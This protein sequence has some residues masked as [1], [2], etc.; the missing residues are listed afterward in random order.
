VSEADLQLAARC[1]AGE[2]QA[3][4]EFVRSYRGFMIDFARR[5]VG[6]TDAD[7]LADSVLADLWER[8][9]LARFEGRSSLRTWL[10]AVVAHAA[11]NHR[12]RR[13]APAAPPHAAAVDASR[14]PLEDAERRRHLRVAL[15]EA[16]GGLAA[17]D[18]VLLL[19]HY[20]QGLTLDEAG[21]VLDASKST[22]SRRLTRTR[23]HLRRETAR[24]AAARFGVDVG[25]LW[26]DGGMDDADFDL[27]A[28]CAPLR[29]A[30]SGDVSKS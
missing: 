10:G 13:P 21:A 17:E 18:R 23:E 8:R 22:L 7:E 14:D 2:E 30:A 16:F 12:R 27:R 1:T 26:R 15:I 29:D 11:L 19:M 25:R 24:I 3:W 28:V 6:G 20:E 4:A 5:I 9:K